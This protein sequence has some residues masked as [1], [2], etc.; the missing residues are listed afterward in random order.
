MKRSVLTG[1][2]I[3]TVV[4]VLVGVVNGASSATAPDQHRSVNSY[5]LKYHPNSSGWD[6]PDPNANR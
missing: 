4:G 3:A 2:L 1:L 6:E 5:V